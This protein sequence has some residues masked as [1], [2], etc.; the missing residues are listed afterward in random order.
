VFRAKPQT[1]VI[2][3][4]SELIKRVGTPS[5][6]PEPPDRFTTAQPKKEQINM[7]KTQNA[8]KQVKKAK[9]TAK[10]K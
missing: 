9:K 6:L 4:R 8:K 5:S 2:C 3:E 10:K 7:A 1:Q